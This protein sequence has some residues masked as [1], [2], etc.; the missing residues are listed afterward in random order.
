[1]VQR[2][3]KPVPVRE[4]SMLAHRE[5]ANYVLMD[6]FKK[7]ILTVV[8]KHMLQATKRLRNRQSMK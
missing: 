4:M 7:Q 2:F 1:M 5:F 8:T 3:Q 6:M